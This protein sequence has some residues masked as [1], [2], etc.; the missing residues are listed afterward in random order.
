MHPAGTAQVTTAV[1][2][3]GWLTDARAGGT[4]PWAALDAARPRQQPKPRC[5]LH[6]EVPGPSRGRAGMGSGVGVTQ[7]L[8]R[9]AS[10][11]CAP[12]KGIQHMLQS[13]RAPPFSSPLLLDWGGT[14]R[15]AVA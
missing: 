1:C 9:A 3:H 15:A 2:H 10:L 5:S 13:R 4:E 12:T 14:S 6:W 8:S 7:E 11:T